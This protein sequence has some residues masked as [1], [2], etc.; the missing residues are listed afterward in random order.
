[1]DGPYCP[2]LIGV[3]AAPPLLTWGAEYGIA[4]PWTTTPVSPVKITAEGK[5]IVTVAA[6]LASKH[7]PVVAPGRG[8]ASVAAE[9]SGPALN[10][11]PWSVKF[12]PSVAG[13]PPQE[14]VKSSPLSVV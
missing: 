2:V 14:M 8:A 9:A 10:C 11:R 7:R 3:S 12:V 4:P 6:P 13:A 5:V 1:M